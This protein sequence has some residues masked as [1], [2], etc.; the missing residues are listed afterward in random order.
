MFNKAL[1]AGLSGSGTP[2]A[3]VGVALVSEMNDREL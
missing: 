1:R 2:T 3:L